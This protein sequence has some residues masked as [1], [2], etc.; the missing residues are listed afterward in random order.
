MFSTQSHSAE[1]ELL[2]SDSKAHL[3]TIVIPDGTVRIVHPIAGDGGAL[4]ADIK[5]AL[6]YMKSLSEPARILQLASREM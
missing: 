6:P 4:N 1:M 5:G 3:Q 2:L